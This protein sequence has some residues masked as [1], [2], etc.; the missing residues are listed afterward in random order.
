M[1]K[2]LKLP[3][4]RVELLAFVFSRFS[5][6]NA[7]FPIILSLHRSKARNTQA[8]RVYKFGIRND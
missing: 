1:Q 4:N 5:G 8:H 6:K 3:G 7:W 2:P